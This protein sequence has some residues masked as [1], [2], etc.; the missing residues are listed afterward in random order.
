MNPML[1]EKLTLLTTKPGCYLMKNKDNQIIYVGKAKNLHRRVNSYFNKMQTGKTKALVDNI[2]DFDYITTNSEMESLILE[3]NLIKKYNPKY[4]ILLKDDKTYPFIALTNEKYPL[5][6]IVR[7]KHRKKTKDKLFGPFPNV[8]SARKT[9]EILNRLYPLRKCNTLK[10]D[11]CLYYHINE[12]L[13]YCKYP[14]EQAKIDNMTKEI[15]NILNGDYRT[16]TKKLEEEMTMASESLNYEK[17]LEI[18][19]TIADIKKTISKQIIVSNLKYNFDVFGF[20]EK[21][22][23]LTIET[24][25]IRDGVVIG[26]QHQI[27]TDY[28]DVYDTYVRYIIDFYETFP[29]PKQIVINPTED[30]EILEEYLKVPVITP[31]KGDIKKILNMSNQNAEVILNE[32]IELIKKDESEKEKAISSLQELL[33]IPSVNRIELFD[34]SHLFGT[35]YV[36]GMVVFENF[37]PKRNEYRKFKIS[38]DVK[39][40]L[41]A[42]KEV[43]Y[44]RYYRVLLENL[45]KPD[46]IIVDGGELQINAVKEVL[47]SLNL[48]IPLMGLKKDE[49]HHTNVIVTETLEEKPLPKDNKLFLYL[50]KMQDEVHRYAITYHRSI[51][52]KGSMASILENISGI[53]EKR[54]KQLLKKY[55]SVNKIKEASI[56]ELAK[57]IP[58]EVAQELKEYLEKE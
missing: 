31:V 21:D 4:N 46:L 10:K 7:S 56:E 42:M 44:R 8:V 49:H 23:L 26:K 39:D 15:S 51:K 28:V 43:I 6:K 53:G 41:S 57:I 20:S 17:A 9:V 27:I 11:V 33:G 48:A 1:K 12:C 24:L 25:F 47:S 2:C 50:T 54:R 58:K 36:G 3:I 30:K 37:T 40:D 29:L 34:N 45:P 13:G 19:N 52:S 55:G 32:K 16:L 14:V 35:Y 18:K 22:H 38:T 5:L